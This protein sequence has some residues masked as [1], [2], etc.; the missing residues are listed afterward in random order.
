MFGIGKR[1]I[2]IKGPAQELAGR[3]TLP[4][5]WTGRLCLIFPINHHAAMGRGAAEKVPH[6]ARAIATG[7]GVDEIRLPEHR[8]LNAEQVCVPMT[9][10]DRTSKR[11]RIED[12]RVAGCVPSAAHHREAA[13][14]KEAA[15]LR[16]RWWRP[17][18]RL[19]CLHCRNAEEPQGIRRQLAGGPRVRGFSEE[20]GRRGEARPKILGATAAE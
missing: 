16:I 10:G 3:A 9:A 15:T 14:R 12:Q 17:M 20:H 4:G 6:L 13:I 5:K 2:T 1:D 19:K 11:T 7:S 18:K 8:T